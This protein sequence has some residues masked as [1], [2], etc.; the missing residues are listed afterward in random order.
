M[1]NSRLQLLRW[2]L[3]AAVQ[4]AACERAPVVAVDNAIWVEHGYDLEDKVA[5]KKFG[6]LVIWIRQK[7]QYTAHHPRTD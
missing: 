1:I 7:S 3:P 6:L 4:V 5:P 2:E